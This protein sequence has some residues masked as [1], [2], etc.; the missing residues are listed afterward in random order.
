M[1]I[2]TDTGS[3]VLFEEC[4]NFAIRGRNPDKLLILQDSDNQRRAVQVSFAKGNSEST[5]KLTIRPASL[6][7][8][9][10][11]MMSAEH[12]KELSFLVLDNVYVPEDPAAWVQGLRTRAVQVGL[13]K[14]PGDLKFFVTT[15]NGDKISPA[16]VNNPDIL[17][18]FVKPIDGRQ[19]LFLLSEF[20]PNKNTLFQFQNIGW[21]QPNLPVHVSKAVELE[22]LS[23]FGATLKSKQPIVPGTILH[24]R[25]SIF[26]NAPEQCVAARV[27]GCEENP[28]EKDQ[29]LIYV[30]YFGITDQFLKFARTWIR[31]NYAQQKGKE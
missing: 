12:S 14:E 27:Y 18:M 16:L 25:K 10:S 6:G 3:K 19:M 20:L 15:D 21:A 31:E 30:T 1:S 7:E 17:G 24:L 9:A 29:F 28:S 5:A 2:I 8:I 26:H 23:E 11:K 4:V 13:V 22:S